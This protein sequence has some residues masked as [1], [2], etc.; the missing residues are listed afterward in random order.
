M[1]EHEIL[2]DPLFNCCRVTF[3]RV[4]ILHDFGGALE[5]N[6]TKGKKLHIL[7]EKQHPINFE[8]NSFPEH[9]ILEKK[10]AKHLSQSIKERCNTV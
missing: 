3:I 6:K 8:A 4:S 9:S 10:Q 1:E 2:C 7:A 5:C